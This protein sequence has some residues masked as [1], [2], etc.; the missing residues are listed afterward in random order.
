M[1]RA[2]RT[3]PAGAQPHEIAVEPPPMPRPAPPTVTR[4]E[5]ELLV[6]RAGLS[7]NPGQK[8]DLALSFQHLVTLAATLPR[9]R[10]LADEPAFVFL[11]PLPASLPQPASS[12]APK[13]AKAGQA[14]KAAAGK[15]AA[16]RPAKPAARPTGKAAVKP[17]GKPAP[18]PA[19]KSGATK[20]AAAKAARRR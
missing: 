7:L 20:P 18:K 11:P 6:R 5:V 17:S 1:N 13:A 3:A 9:A 12:P 16:S 15:A 10:P 4:D 19:V 14:P 2:G 8:A